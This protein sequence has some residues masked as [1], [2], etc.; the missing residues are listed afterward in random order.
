MKNAISGF[1]I[2]TTALDKAQAFFEA[3]VDKPMR[4]VNMEPSKGAMFACDK[5]SGGVRVYSDGNRV[6]LH[7]LA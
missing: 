1:E 2:P 5:A 6:G 4:S 7:A 3:L